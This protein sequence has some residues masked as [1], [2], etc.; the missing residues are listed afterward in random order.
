M[1]TPELLTRDAELRKAQLH[2]QNTRTL[3]GLTNRLNHLCDISKKWAQQDEAS[4]EDFERLEIASITSQIYK[5]ENDIKQIK[6]LMGEPVVDTA[7]TDEAAVEHTSSPSTYG[8]F[9]YK[10][11]QSGEVVAKVPMGHLGLVDCYYDPVTRIAR[12][13]PLNPI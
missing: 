6:I 1:F 3:T 7:S 2:A 12:P 4:L 8:V 10:G 13:V 11:K 9:D 5:I